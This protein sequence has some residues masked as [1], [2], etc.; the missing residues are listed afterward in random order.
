[1]KN[2]EEAPLLQTDAM[3]H[4]LLTDSGEQ[5]GVEVGSCQLRVHTHTVGLTYQAQVAW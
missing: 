3:Q 4:I 1:M 2:P 5:S